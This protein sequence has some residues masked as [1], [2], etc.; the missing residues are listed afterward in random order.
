MISM[1]RN[2]KLILT[3]SLGTIL[4]PQVAF[5][6]SSWIWVTDKRPFD[7]LPAVAA[8]TIIIEV[9][10]IWLIPHTGRF[11]KTSVVVVT[12]NAV[13]FLFPFFLVLVTDTWY[14]SFQHKLDHWPHYI[15]GGLFLFITLLLEVPI[16]YLL[17]KKDVKNTRTL[18]ITIIA[19]NVVTTAMV[20][21]VERLITDGYWV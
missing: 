14:G 13:S 10:A 2:G 5:A 7:I 1:N 15:V 19:T 17:L 9:L 12:A 8:A 3:I 6:D 21:V 4:I 11:I 18:L 20:A 16:T